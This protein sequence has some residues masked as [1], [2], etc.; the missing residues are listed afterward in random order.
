[1]VRGVTDTEEDED[2]KEMC[3]ESVD[4][5]MEIDRSCMI[6]NG[7]VDEGSWGS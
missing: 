5:Y 2:E 1:M 7:M 6:A 4:R 3:R